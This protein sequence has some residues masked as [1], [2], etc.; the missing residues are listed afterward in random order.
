[1][2]PFCQVPVDFILQS[3]ILRI[4]RQISGMGVTSLKC[5]N[6]NLA[7]F[8]KFYFNKTSQIYG[9]AALESPLGYIGYFALNIA[10]IN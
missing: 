3:P 4:C 8:L 7:L 5:L 6:Q 1:M 10:S 9:S 2:T